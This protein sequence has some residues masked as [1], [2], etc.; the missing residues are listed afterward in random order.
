MGLY[1]HMGLLAAIE[2]SLLE[3]VSMHETII[4]EIHYSF[5]SNLISMHMGNIVWH[6]LT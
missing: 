3:N 1:L 5:I 4:P 2:T 6:D